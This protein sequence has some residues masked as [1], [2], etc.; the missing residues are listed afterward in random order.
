[1]SKYIKKATPIL[2]VIAL[3]LVFGITSG[4]FSTDLV[5]SA[6]KTDA[7]RIVIDSE[8][9]GEAEQYNVGSNKLADSDELLEDY[10]LKTA[11][12]ELGT[13]VT[14]ERPSAGKHLTGADKKAYDLLKK[15]IERVANGDSTDTVFQISFKDL[16]PSE[17]FEK[18]YTTDNLHLAS[19]GEYD[20]AENTFNLS[21][22]AM[23]TMLEDFPL[24]TG[25]V[26][27]ALV[28]DCPYHLYW[29]D[30]TKGMT[31]ESELRRQNQ[32]R[33]SCFRCQR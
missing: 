18:E 25:K 32:R 5:F 15:E 4:S 20:E 14:S 29:F 24:D 13:D 12:E 3:S 16:F 19:L 23:N 28:A 27:R 9:S 10:M 22:D 21:D 30:K 8:L 26:F 1:M 11:Q 7:G 17:S 6:E 2:S 31:T 33:K